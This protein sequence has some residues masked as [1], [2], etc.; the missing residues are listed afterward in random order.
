[1][2]GCIHIINDENG[3]DNNRPYKI[4]VISVVFFT[5][6]RYNKNGFASGFPFFTNMKELLAAD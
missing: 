3:K 1:M 4:D 5:D 6:I 2:S